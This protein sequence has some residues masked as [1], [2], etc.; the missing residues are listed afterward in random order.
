MIG[1]VQAAP[2]IPCYMPS[3]SRPP[4]RC[5]SPHLD[6][7][8]TQ[9]MFYS[10]KRQQFLIDQGYAFKVLAQDGRASQRSCSPRPLLGDA[11]GT[12]LALSPLQLCMTLACACP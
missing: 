5:A 4:I 9:E 10:A 6:R 2:D 12:V 1:R 11:E 8:D 7:R 3:L